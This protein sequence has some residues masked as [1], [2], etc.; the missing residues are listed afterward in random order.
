MIPTLAAIA[1]TI[2]MTTG[3]SASGDWTDP[4]PNC[5]MM[6]ARY[7]SNSCLTSSGCPDIRPSAVYRRF[8]T[9]A[10]PSKNPATALA[11]KL[12]VSSAT[13]TASKE[14]A[15]VK[16]ATCAH[17]AKNEAGFGTASATPV[18]TADAAVAAAPTATYATQTHPAVA[19]ADTA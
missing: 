18:A 6:T 5:E 19:A 2:V 1:A 12:R 3:A 17:H 14:Y 13:P 4:N 11:A 16:A 9:A 15:K 7:P 8:S 10:P